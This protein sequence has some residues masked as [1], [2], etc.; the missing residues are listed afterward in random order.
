MKVQGHFQDLS[1]KM[2]HLLGHFQDK[3]NSQDI[4]RISRTSGHPAFFAYFGQFLK[5]LSNL[6][7]T[8]FCQMATKCKINVIGNLKISLLLCILS[9]IKIEYFFGS[10]GRYTMQTFCGSKIQYEI[11][12][13]LEL[14]L[15]GFI[16][17]REVR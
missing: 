7:H 10:P 2:G 12:Q 5:F 14:K 9:L 13:I 4:S 11:N 15:F 1:L 8:Y 6:K 16:E 3:I 17:W